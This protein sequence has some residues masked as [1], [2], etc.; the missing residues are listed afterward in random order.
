[1]DPDQDQ[2][3]ARISAAGVLRLRSSMGPAHALGLVVIGE[4]FDGDFGQGLV[5]AFNEGGG[6][7]RGEGK[8]SGIFLLEEELGGDA[9]GGGAEGEAQGQDGL[10][11]FR[12]G[13]VAEK[14]ADIDFNEDVGFQRAA[15][16]D[17][18]AEVTLAAQ[19]GA[20]GG[21]EFLFGRCQKR[22]VRIAGKGE[23]AFPGS[24]VASSTTSLP[25]LPL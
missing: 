7:G 4:G 24:G 9:V 10:R 5:P 20:Q 11:V 8:A 3:L 16:F 2:C 6:G 19:G 18:G 13:E 23:V 12:P 21:T 14:L 25:S 1:M 15:S 17:D 22:G